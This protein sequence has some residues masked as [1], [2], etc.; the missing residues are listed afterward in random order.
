MPP[1][2]DPTKGA[3]PDRRRQLMIYGGVAIALLLVV[4]F[5]RRSSSSSWSTSPSSSSDIDPATGVPY[6]EEEAAYE[7][8]AS[9]AG[10]GADGVDDSSELAGI[11]SDIQT[12]AQGVQAL[13]NASQNAG[14]NTPGTTG[15]TGDTI[16][17]LPAT[18]AAAIAAGVAGVQSPAPSQ[19]GPGNT[20][21][22]NPTSK[23]VSNSPSLLAPGV[24]SPNYKLV[25]PAA[26]PN[27]VWA[28][29]KSPGSNYTGV[30]GGWYVK[31]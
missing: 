6:S 17:D 14:S 11:D 15:T 5:V 29:T 1:G 13:Q 8:G 23:P 24:S 27:A 28:G 3:K 7:S 25:R 16:S 19:P 4:V 9:D 2:L 31:K 22:S 21:T 26:H 30:G 20:P 18:I 12:L 10:G